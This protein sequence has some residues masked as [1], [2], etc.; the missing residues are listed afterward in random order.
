MPENH[1]ADKNGG[2]TRGNWSRVGVGLLAVVPFC[3]ACLASGAP[4]QPQPLENP[5]EFPPLAFAQYSLDFGEV[6]ATPVINAHFDFVNRSDAPVEILG[7]KP[8]CNC[9]NPTLMG[10]RTTYAPGEAGRFH[11]Q[12]R[13]ANEP[14]GQQDYLVELDYLDAEDRVHTEALILR[15]TLPELKVTVEPSELLFYQLSGEAGSQTIHVTDFRDDPLEVL[16]VVS[17]SPYASFEIGEAEVDEFGRSTIPIQISIP[18]G[19]PPMR[20]ITLINIMTSDQEFSQLQVPMLLHGPIQSQQ[21]M[22]AASV[23]PAPLPV[24]STD[25]PPDD[26]GDP[27]T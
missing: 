2:S 24:P 1:T 4:D 11:I 16:E 12:V 3:I 9:L 17:D 6:P 21:V 5:R 10:G 15:V 26:D 18:E 19:I 20:E 7:L 27:Q 22:P 8:S 25:T 23:L 14:A 13:T